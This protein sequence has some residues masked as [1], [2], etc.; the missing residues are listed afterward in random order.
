M[1]FRAF[2]GVVCAHVNVGGFWREF[3]IVGTR[4]AGEFLGL[5]G[6]GHVVEDAFFEF[7]EGFLGP[8]A[9]VEKIDRL[10]G[11][12]EVHRDHGELHAA[13]ALEE[14][15]GVVVGDGKMFA[16]AG[17]GGGV[18]AFEFGRT[19][20]HFHDGHA[21]AVPVEEFFADALQD[22]EREGCGSCVEVV[23]ALGGAGCGGGA[24]DG[25]ILSVL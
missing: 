22:G 16:Q 5:S 17:F 18:D 21:G 11:K 10:A 20:R 9:G 6:G 2:D 14:K 13:A 1:I 24:H 15:D 7:G 23:G 8:G 12:T 4:D 3:Y 19:V 25:L